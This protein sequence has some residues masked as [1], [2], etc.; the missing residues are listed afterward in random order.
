MLRRRCYA[1][2]FRSGVSRMAFDNT[3][4][5]NDLSGDTAG[6]GSKYEPNARFYQR[7]MHATNRNPDFLEDSLLGGFFRETVHDINQHGE[8][9]TI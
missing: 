8:D 3:C 1:E 2:R 5:F 4:S 7:N 9:K 6:L